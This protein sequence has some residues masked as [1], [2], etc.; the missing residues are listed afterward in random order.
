MD[1]KDKYYEDLLVED[2]PKIS[3]TDFELLEELEDYFLYKEAVCQ[4]SMTNM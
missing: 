2:K 1:Y 3:M 4:V